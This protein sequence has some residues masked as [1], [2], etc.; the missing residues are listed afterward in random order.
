[1]AS[2][3]NPL[4]VSTI[5]GGD[6]LDL[7]HSRNRSSIFSSITVWQPNGLSHRPLGA[8]LS[9]PTRCVGAWA[10]DNLVDAAI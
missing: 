1:M 10:E 9:T 2:H 4:Q 8:P 5:F 3:R 6:A 7:I